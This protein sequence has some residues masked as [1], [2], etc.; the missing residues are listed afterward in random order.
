M[1]LSPVGAETMKRSAIEMNF[2]TMAA[3]SQKL[4]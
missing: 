2:V 4:I 1:I 3:S